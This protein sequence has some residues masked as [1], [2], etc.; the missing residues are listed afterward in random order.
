MAWNGASSELERGIAPSPV[1]FTS[2]HI[3]FALPGPVFALGNQHGAETPVPRALQNMCIE[4][5]HHIK[6]SE[7][8]YVCNYVACRSQ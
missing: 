2:H 8:M 4:S 7:G 5:K 1:C 6:N 3:A